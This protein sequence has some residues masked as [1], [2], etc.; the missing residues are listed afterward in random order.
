MKKIIVIIIS[1]AVIAGGAFFFLKPKKDIQVAETSINVKTSSPIYDSFKRNKSFVGRIMPESSVSVMPLVPDT[2]INVNKQVG[3]HVKKGELLFSVDPDSVKQN[4]DLALAALELEKAQI[5]Q[6]NGSTK[7]ITL[8]QRELAYKTAQSQYDLADEDFDQWKDQSDANTDKLEGQLSK[9]QKELESE[10]DPDKQSKLQDQIDDIK[11]QI[12]IADKDYDAEKESKKLSLKNS[13]IALNDAKKDY[14]RELNQLDNEAKA[15]NDAKLSKSKATYENALSY[16][17]KTNVYAPI[18]GIVEFKGI[19]ENAKANPASPAYIISNKKMMSVSFGIPDT[20]IK[21]ISIN[22]K[23]EIDYN[24][25]ICEGHISEI[26]LSA[27]PK[28]GL[29]NIKAVT[30]TDGQMLSG[31]TVT[32]NLAVEK[33]ENALT[34]PTQA[35]V[36]QDGDT[37]VY[38]ME[39]NKAVKKAVKLGVITQTNAEVLEGL[40]ENDK[41]ILTK[42]TK[43]AN[44]IKVVDITN[45]KTASIENLENTQTELEEN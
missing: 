20:F 13:L 36:Y 27:D 29:Y 37:F 5:E 31:T 4:V 2:V 41:V 45:S 8:L 21:E 26:S 7:A 33:T 25:E 6:E 43:I 3:E 34:I 1:L 32:V 14:D 22:D 35:I 39:D 19:E 12:K 11:Y 44:G 28:S 15:I 9:L 30:Q 17:E 16:L 42:S 24:G 38:T 18:D 10:T 23:V 40:S